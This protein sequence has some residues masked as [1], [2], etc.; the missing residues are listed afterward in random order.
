MER[1]SDFLRWAL[2]IVNLTIVV[3]CRDPGTLELVWSVRKGLVGQ[4]GVWGEEVFTVGRYLG[5]YSVSTGRELRRVKLPQDYAN[6]TLGQIGPEVA[7]TDSSLVFGW[8][9]FGRVEGKEGKIFCYDPKT[10]VLRWERAFEW[11][12]EVRET[13][14]T[15][16][17]VI[18]GDYLYALAAAKKGQNL[19][20]LKL[21]D[22]QI[23]WSTTIEKFVK[24]VPP[25]LLDGKLLVGSI[26]SVWHPNQYGYLQAVESET[27][28]V[29]WKVRID[30]VSLFDDPPLISGDR[31]YL[32]SGAVLSDPNHFYTVDLRR[33]TIANHQRVHQLRAPFAEHKGILYFGN[34]TPAAFDISHNK[35]LWQNDLRG[36]HG[37]GDPF[38]ARGVLDPIKSEI[39]LG[40]EK[41]NLYVLSS[42]TGQVKDK[43]NI[44]GY[45][46]GEFFSPLKVFFGS[47]GVERLALV[48]GLLFVGTV[49]KSLFVFRRADKN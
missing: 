13:R 9:D 15:F 25:V 18:D 23:V 16:T 38:G 2:V 26:V 11:P 37:L 33:G 6:I 8:Y 32:T 12:W 30:G 17:V 47:Y 14:P 19:F 29:L 45:W 46:R 44:R 41:W 3:G 4:W 1:H 36:P 35:I 48:E 20:K 39:Y 7:I 42:T 31:A 49:D 10:L 40:D 24:S 34:N 5:V 21:S 22:G 28:K 27:G 43:L